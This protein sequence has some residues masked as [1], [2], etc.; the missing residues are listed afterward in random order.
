MKK[1]AACFCVFIMLVSSALHGNEIAYYSAL[2]ISS[3]AGPGFDD[4]LD[5]MQSREGAESAKNNPIIG[6]SLG[7]IAEK[8]LSNTLSTRGELALSARGGGYLLKYEDGRQA[9]TLLSEIDLQIPFLIRY[10][11]SIDDDNKLYFIAGPSFSILLISKAFIQ[12]GAEFSMHSFPETDPTLIG[13]SA[14]G[15]IGVELPFS[16]KR[17]FFE[18]RALTELND[19]ITGYSHAHQRQICFITGIK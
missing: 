19:S 14:V 18:L 13:L 1:Q 4:Y 16:G 17:I 8:Q 2:S 3:Y 11:T 10:T 6:V 12:D 9:S 5:D 15:G 7:I